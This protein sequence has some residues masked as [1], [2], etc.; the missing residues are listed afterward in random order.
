MKIKHKLITS[1]LLLMVLPLLLL[2][3]ATFY[4]ID[5]IFAEVSA[6][7]IDDLNSEAVT[8]LTNT[9]KLKAERLN[10]YLFSQQLTLE[11]LANSEGVKNA[12]D[13]LLSYQNS[14]EI[15]PETDYIIDS[16]EYRNIWAHIKS[17]FK[18]YVSEDKYNWYDVFIISKNNGQIM[19]TQKRES[20]LGQSLL[21]G[22]LKT[23][24][25][26]KLYAKI[27]NS[28]Q[29]EF[30]DFSPYSPSGNIPAA[31]I[32]CPIF[33]NHV[34]Q[35]ILALQLPIEKINSI[36][37]GNAG[38]GKTGDSYLVGADLKLR[39]TPRHN[40]HEAL[41]I[42]S[43]FKDNILFDSEKTRNALTGKTATILNADTVKTGTTVFS[44]YRPFTFL[45]VT[46]ALI[47]EIEQTEIFHTLNHFQEHIAEG[48]NYILLLTAAMLL[49]FIIIGIC[50]VYI[51]AHKLSNPITLVGSSLHK[52]S[53]LTAQL[54]NIMKNNLATGDWSKFISIT[55]T[56]SLREDI[57][58]FAAAKDEIGQMCS[59]TLEILDK[60]QE[61]A[62]STNICIRQMNHTIENVHTTV[63]EVS[64]G[65]AQVSAA[66]QELSEGAISSS[67]AM[68]QINATMTEIESQTVANAENSAHASELSRT[69]TTAALE[70]RDKMAEMCT[71]MESINRNSEETRKIIKTID[72]IA[73]QTNLL[74]LNAA[75]EAAR[76]GNY[77]KGFAV[78]AEEVRNLAT[79]SANASRETAKLIDKSYSEVQHGLEISHA[80][81]KIL[82]KVSDNIIRTADLMKQVT[83][84]S[85]EQAQAIKEINLS[86]AQIDGITQQNAVKAEE[87]A[88]ASEQMTTQA[89]ELRQQI[90]NFILAENTDY[91]PDIAEDKYKFN[92]LT[93]IMNQLLPSCNAAE[94]LILAPTV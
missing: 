49:L 81:E 1:H 26:G 40:N 27:L 35:G 2:S 88:S 54:S 21:H 32:G 53:T 38:L 64:S 4:T 77:G 37:Q 7:T 23:E 3:A 69:A 94:H 58:R 5:S 68:E 15:T 56:D 91:D 90:D 59:A 55:N 57:D 30:I 24:G 29:T 48:M 34:F 63:L 73:F 6:E 18:N 45:G 41:T 74:A 31:F 47:T 43:S 82:D 22:S 28:Q 62:L 87:T 9:G 79:R 52:L 12:F 65:S 76:A 44:N 83:S 67:S 33:S 66:S 80:S 61:S 11:T 10:D 8:T 51:I 16:K 89:E 19:Y 86:L 71:A 85:N 93:P 14:H 13:K 42:S 50:I 70:S 17:N 72:D 84:A 20:D 25:I 78:V 75:V 36:M 60:T 92:T 39:S 46:W